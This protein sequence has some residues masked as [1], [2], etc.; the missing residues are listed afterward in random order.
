M[1]FS[2]RLKPHTIILGTADDEILECGTELEDTTL[3]VQNPLGMHPAWLHFQCSPALLILPI[4]FLNSLATL[5]SNPSSNPP[6]MHDLD[7][8]SEDGKEEDLSLYALH[9]NYGN[10][11]LLSRIEVRPTLLKFISALLVMMQPLQRHKRQARIFACALCSYLLS[12]PFSDVCSFILRVLFLTYP[13]SSLSLSLFSLLFPLCFLG[14]E[15]RWLC[16]L[17]LRNLLSST[18][19]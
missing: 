11:D 14:C 17:Q 5:L 15:V 2:S 3:F 9:V 12:F 16:G 13:L 19:Y 10:E 1:L 8:F 18:C 6:D 7:S 4:E